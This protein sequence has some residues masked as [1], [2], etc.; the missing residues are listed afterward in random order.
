L[1]SGQINH[2]TISIE[3][4]EPDS[5]PAVVKITWPAQATVV[6]PRSFG[7]TTAALVKMF[8]TAHVELARIKSRRYR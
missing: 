8:S 2:D 4:V 7:D 6:D 5:L 1:A 3:L